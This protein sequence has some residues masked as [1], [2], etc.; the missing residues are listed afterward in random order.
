[1]SLTKVFVRGNAWVFRRTNGRLG[2][3]MG[4]QSVLLLNTVGRKSGRT[5][6]TP[7]SY[8]RDG[9]NYLVVA[10]NWGQEEP[11]DWFRNLMQNRRTTIQVKDETMQVEARQ[12]EGEE[13]ARLWKLV[14]SQNGQYLA[15]Q[16]KVTRQIPVVVLKPV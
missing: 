12:A 13:Y 8:F 10:S 3:R 4:K 11:P 5:Y 14:T 15:Y 7:L 16:K 6:T 1:M 2:S 9:P